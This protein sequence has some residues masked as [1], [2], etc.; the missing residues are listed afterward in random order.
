MITKQAGGLPYS[1]DFLDQLTE[2]LRQLA[3]DR[4][5]SG[6]TPAEATK[7]LRAA[8]L[9]RRINNENEQELAK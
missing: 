5:K 7:L 6:G 8:D 9:V 1:Y 2:D 4:E 3:V